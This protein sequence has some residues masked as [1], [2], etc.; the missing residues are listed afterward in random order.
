M[1]IIPEEKP[2]LSV[3]KVSINE[4]TGTHG[5]VP[6]TTCYTQN[7]SLINTRFDKTPYE[8]INNRKLDVSFLHV[9]E[10]LCYPKNDCEDIGKLGAKEPELHG[11][12]FKTICDDYMGSQ[13]SD[14]IRTARVAPT[15]QNHQTLNE[16]TTTTIETA[17]TPTNS[18]T[19]TSIFPTTS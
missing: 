17:L 11:I 13:S 14:A 6:T 3:L 5:V 1:E 15:T 18:S 16:S 19:K 8:L 10:A 4:D 9:F 2:L 12:L 7:R